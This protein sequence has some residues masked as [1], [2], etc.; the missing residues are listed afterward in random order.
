MTDTKT[1]QKEIVSLFS[2]RLNGVSVI[3][4]WNVAK[5]RS[6]DFDRTVLYAPRVD[7]AIGPFMIN[8]VTK[9]EKER[10]DNASESNKQLI[11]ELIEIGEE[12]KPFEYN[13]NPRCLIAVEIEN[14]GSIK[15][16]IGDITNAS[17][18]GKIGLIVPTSE[19][20]YK[21][22]KRIMAYLEFAQKNNKI[23]NNVF[24]NIVLIK[25]DTLINHLGEKSDNETP[26]N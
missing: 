7:V 11:D 22:F 17:I 18:L 10:F 9:E 26:H 2:K 4:E 6:D 19:K 5:N 3:E 13:K 24:K 20:S 14:S 25:S 1:I 21:T 8:A 16:H 15:H 23:N 12:F